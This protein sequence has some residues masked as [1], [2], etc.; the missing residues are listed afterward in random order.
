M[1]K[2]RPIGCL[3][4]QRHIQLREGLGL[5]AFPDKGHGFV[6]P[7]LRDFEN[8][9]VTDL[10]QGTNYRSRTVEN[11]FSLFQKLK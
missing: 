7:A 1:A 2:V 8:K 4:H 6:Q 9:L 11:N 10:Q 3:R 5:H